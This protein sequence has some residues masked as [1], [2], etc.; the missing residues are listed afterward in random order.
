MPL[1]TETKHEISRCVSEALDTLGKEGKQILMHYLDAHMGL[2]EEEIPQK[3]EL[4]SKG[5]NLILGEQ[6]ANTLETTIAQELQT[7]FKLL[8]NSKL[9]FTEAIN[10]I[11]ER[12]N[13]S[14]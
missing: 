7:S 8:H 2:K 10:I 5:L 9:T 11:K 4:F 14:C 12:R 3:P 6:G 13:K 1:D